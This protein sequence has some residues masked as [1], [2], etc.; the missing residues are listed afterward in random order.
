MIICA[1]TKPNISLRKS[2]LNRV[3]PSTSNPP[4]LPSK[5]NKYKCV[6]R[7]LEAELEGITKAEKAPQKKP[8][9]GISVPE[10]NA[11]P[12]TLDLSKMTK[13]YTD[14]G[15]EQMIY[16]E[17]DMCMIMKRKVAKQTADS[18]ELGDVVLSLT[19]K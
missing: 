18:R 8:K 14:S 13:I 7:K 3:H 12:A 17:Q 4:K 10:F 6:K 9:L 2:P 16:L 15:F 11:L 1:P 19:R 5:A